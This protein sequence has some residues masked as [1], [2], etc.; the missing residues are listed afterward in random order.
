[1]R[2]TPEPDIKRVIR[3]GQ[4]YNIFYQGLK[5]QRMSSHYKR[6]EIKDILNPLTSASSEGTNS[7]KPTDEALHLKAEK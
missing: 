3:F 2:L 1:M 7:Q 6:V 4:I 5:I